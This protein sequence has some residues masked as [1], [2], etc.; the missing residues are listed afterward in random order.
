MTLRDF[1]RGP[2]EKFQFAPESRWEECAAI[3]RGCP[4]E[5][6][7]RWLDGFCDENI[8]AELFF[9]TD[10]EYGGFS[11]FIGF[12]CNFAERRAFV[13]EAARGFAGGKFARA[14]DFIAAAE[15]EFRAP[16]FA[17]LPDFMELGLVNMWKSFGALSFAPMSENPYAALSAAVSASPSWR[18]AL[19]A[20]PACEFAF[21]SPLP[22]W[23][24]VCL[25]RPF[26][27]VYGLDMKKAEAF[28]K[29]LRPV[30]L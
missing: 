14:E 18:G 19:P 3:S 13:E 17:G 28:M 6:V 10:G 2:A 15:N 20:P 16:L 30:S 22:H 9:E 7:L 5:A 21:S 24:G 8:G 11:A 25:S 29:K 4:S 27:E 1:V 12:R 23:F 26:N